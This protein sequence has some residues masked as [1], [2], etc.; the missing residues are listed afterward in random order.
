MLTACFTRLLRMSFAAIWLILAI[1]L[2]RL[3]FQR[4]PRRILCL[5]WTLAAIRLLIP[6]SLQS[7]FSLQPSPAQLTAHLQTTADTAQTTLPPIMTFTPEVPIPQ[8]PTDII[9]EQEQSSPPFWPDVAAV[10][11]PIGAAGMIAYALI[12]TLMLRR[13]SSFPCFSG[14][15]HF[16]E[17]T[18]QLFSCLFFMLP[19][20]FAPC[21]DPFNSQL[22]SNSNLHPSARVTK[23]SEPYCVSRSSSV[24]GLCSGS[25]TSFSS[26]N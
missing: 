8:N 26:V 19:R 6:F 4:A 1:L 11:W 18:F 10:L 12:S 24:A 20:P 25:V 16:T 9:S 14:S 3:I 2:L 13:I 22:L 17:N 15:C 23:Y 5:L 21:C 7:E